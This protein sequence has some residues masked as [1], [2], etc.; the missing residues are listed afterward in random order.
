MFETNRCSIQT[1][2]GTDFQDVS[3]LYLNPQVRRFLG[4]IRQAEEMNEVLES[5]VNPAVDSYYW[6]IREK[7]SQL[8]IGLVSLDP[9][10]DGEYLEISYQFLPIWW[11]R[12]YGAEVV[13]KIIHYAFEELKLSKVVAET[14]IANDASCRLLEKVGM[15]LERTINRFGAEQAIYSIEY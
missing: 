13:E 2:R 12:G 3:E 6:V 15:K 11:G 7:E 14:Q 10:H 4:G 8:F 9:H 5:M 1:F